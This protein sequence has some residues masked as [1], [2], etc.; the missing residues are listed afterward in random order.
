[1]PFHSEPVRRLLAGV[2]NGSL[3]NPESESAEDP[4]EGTYGRPM[5]YW[6]DRAKSLLFTRF[7]LLGVVLGETVSR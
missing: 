6:N 3:L 4:G 2:R 5:G 7:G 1:M